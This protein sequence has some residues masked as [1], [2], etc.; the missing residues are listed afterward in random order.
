MNKK[1]K[2]ITGLGAVSTL[3]CLLIFSYAKPYLTRR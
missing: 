2:L 1:T 3:I